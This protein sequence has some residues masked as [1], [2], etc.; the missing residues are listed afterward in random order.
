[1][2][3]GRFNRILLV[4]I[5]LVLVV[6]ALLLI[7][8]KQYIVDQITVWQFNPTDAI[9]SL[10]DRSGMNDYGKFLFFAEKPEL[11]IASDFNKSC[12]R[13][14]T[15]TSILGC[16]HND[17]I[18]LYDVTDAQLDGVREVTATHETLHAAYDRMDTSEKAKVDA[19]LEVEYKKLVSDKN[20]ADRIAFYDRTEPGQRDNE[21]HS[22][23]GTEVTSI[24]PEL[25]SYY[26]KYFSN[27]QTIVALNNK[28]IGVFKSLENRANILKAQLDSLASSVSS[29]SSK[30][31]AD[32]KLLNS[33]I[34][35]F[36]SRADNGQFS[37]QAQFNYERSLLVARANSLELVR[38]SINN[39]VAKYNLLLAELNSIA[40]E[41]KKLYNSLDSTLAPVP[42]V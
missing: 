15:T 8:N 25:E 27:R 18:Y 31:N 26:S 1:M 11:Q 29:R 42:S 19:L 3:Q 39:D 40:S 22:V 6:L 16:Y 30:Y 5:S 24:S 23:I 2:S 14:E 21:L 13:V 32:I 41:S 28:Y 17:R 35:S 7:L 34:A 37:S 38:T 4:I 20:F 9:K 12:D 36:N 33:D 10:A